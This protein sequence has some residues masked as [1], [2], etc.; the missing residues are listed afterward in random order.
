[1]LKEIISTIS[2]AFGLFLC[3]IA[4]K[5]INFILEGVLLVVTYLAALLSGEAENSSMIGLL[6]IGVIGALLVNAG[7]VSLAVGSAMSASIAIA[8]YSF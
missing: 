1:M 4:L 3:M 8:G 2:L 6:V 7:F 5:M